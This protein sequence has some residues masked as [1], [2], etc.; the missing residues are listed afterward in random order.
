MPLVSFGLTMLGPVLLKYASEEQ[1]QEHL[2]KMVRGQIRWCQGYSGISLLE[3]IQQPWRFPGRLSGRLNRK[4]L[5]SRPWA[6][7]PNTGSRRAAR[8][9]DGCRGRRLMR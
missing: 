9:G 7:S 8:C 1:K 4:A 3:S 2:P 6:G 5:G